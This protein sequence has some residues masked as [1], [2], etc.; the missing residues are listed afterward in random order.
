[1]ECCGVRCS[2]SITELVKLRFIYCRLFTHLL[3][4]LF[5][6]EPSWAGSRQAPDSWNAKRWPVRRWL[7]AWESAC[8]VPAGN[9]THKV[10]VWATHQLR[11]MCTKVSKKQIVY[12]L[13]HQNYDISLNHREAL[14]LMCFEKQ[15]SL[16]TGKKGN[17]GHQNDT[18]KQLI[19]VPNDRQKRKHWSPK[20]THNIA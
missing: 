11:K 13:E 14:S 8:L 10:V 12:F 15:L 6:P 4:S 20:N 3:L 7:F 17:T 9:R 19:T 5:S 1:M 16:M 2:A 18:A